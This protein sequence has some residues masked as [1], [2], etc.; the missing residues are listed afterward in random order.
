MTSD[1]LG[2]CPNCGLRWD[3]NTEAHC[4]ACCRHFGSDA[5]FDRHVGLEKRM[6]LPPGKRKPVEVVDH[7]CKDPSNIKLLKSIGRRGITVWVKN[8]E[9]DRLPPGKVRPG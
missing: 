8:V 3:S 9:S 2:Y 7:V 5:A 1:G 4:A 6:V